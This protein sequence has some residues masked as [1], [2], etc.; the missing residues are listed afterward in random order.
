MKGFIYIMSNSSFKDG[1]L[2]IGK[3]SRHPD[4][5]RKKELETTG[6]PDLFFV[7]Y[8][9]FVEKYSD[10][11]V[12]IHRR[13]GNK[14][15]RS[16]REF[17]VL[18]IEHAIFELKSVI[19]D[20]LVHEE[21]GDSSKISLLGNGEIREYYE[22][23]DLKVAKKLKYFIA[24]GTYEEFFV[25]GERKIRTNYCD[26]KENGMRKEYSKEG[27][28]KSWGPIFLGKKQGLWKTIHKN[29]VEKRHYDEGKPVLDWEIYSKPGRLIVNN[30]GMPQTGYENRVFRGKPEL[31]E[32]LQSKK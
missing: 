4:S 22:N 23:G 15:H 20:R 2:K 17:F 8:S 1:F 21:F 16:N 13:L 32:Y 31:D 6:V 12:E 10:I 25:G 26:G 7:E 30:Y 18:D 5:F 3:S 28:L 14:R 11:E 9:A 27:V 29:G 19:G 24:H